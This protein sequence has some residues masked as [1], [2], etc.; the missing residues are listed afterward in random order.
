MRGAE[1]SSATVGRRDTQGSGAGLH[2][3]AVREA[4]GQRFVAMFPVML[5]VSELVVVST[6]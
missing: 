4:A 6:D 2:V 3:V 5:M 1:G